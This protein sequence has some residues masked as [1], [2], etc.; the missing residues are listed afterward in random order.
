MFMNNSKKLLI[1]D[2]DGVIAD[3]EKLWLKNRMMTIN[4]KFGLNWDYKITYKYLGGMSDKTKRKVLNNMGLITD[5]VFWEENY[6]LDQ[7]DLKKGFDLTDGI[8]NIFKYTVLK[9]CIAT[10]GLKEKTKQKIDVVGIR[11]Y[12]PENH[13]FT[14]DMVEK[15]KP[16]P[17]LFLF[18][19]KKMNEKPED[20]IVIEDSIAGMEAAK[21]ANMDVIAFIGYENRKEIINEIKNLDISNIFTNMGDIY[22]YL[23]KI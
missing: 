11:K 22:N 12:F 14:A 19:A 5:D 4:Q 17:D 7:L 10:G 3:T 20:C 1:W 6:K 9:Q 15:G 18:A 16:E 23:K 13:V 21:K 8:E 2:F